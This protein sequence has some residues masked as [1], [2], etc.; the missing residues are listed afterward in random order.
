MLSFCKLLKFTL[1]KSFELR[2][3]EGRY[4][5]R[6]KSYIQSLVKTF[7]T[8][9]VNYFH[10]L[11]EI[12]P[13]NNVGNSKKAKVSSSPKGKLGHTRSW[14]LNTHTFLWAQSLKAVN[15]LVYLF[16][17]TSP[18]LTQEWIENCLY[19][20]RIACSNQNLESFKTKGK[21]CESWK[22]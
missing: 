21:K 2:G 18:R 11:Y 8:F 10:Q 20:L 17:I 22:E 13:H 14:H 4:T 9:Q 15:C 7:I 12:V 1:K 6:H 3:F 19:I 16:G 5:V